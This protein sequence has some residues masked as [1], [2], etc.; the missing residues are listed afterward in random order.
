VRVSEVCLGLPLESALLVWAD[1]NPCHSGTCAAD[2]NARH[3][4]GYENPNHVPSILQ[5]ITE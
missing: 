3:L 2:R 4:Y 1:A 5:K